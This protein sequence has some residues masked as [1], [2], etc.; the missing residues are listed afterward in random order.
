MEVDM[1]ISNMEVDMYI[2]IHIID[3]IYMYIYINQIRY[4]QS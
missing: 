4:A 3:Y 2:S 1:Y